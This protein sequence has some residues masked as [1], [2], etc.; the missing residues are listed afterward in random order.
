MVRVTQQSVAY[1]LLLC[2]SAGLVY[3]IAGGGFGEP[4]AE[5]KLAP[6]TLAA[7]VVVPD[8]SGDWLHR[9][10]NYQPPPPGYGN[11]PL[12]N[13]IDSRLIWVGD[14]KNPILKPW[15]AEI[16]KQHGEQEAAG[17]YIPTARAT[18]WPTGVPN[19]MNL[20]QP[21]RILQTPKEVVILYE[22][23]PQVRIIYLNQKHSANPEPSWHGESVGHYEGDTLVVDTIGLN[24]KSWID[25]FGTPST[26]ALHVVERFRVTDGGTRLQ[27]IATVED[28]NTFNQPWSG[29]A[30]YGPSDRPLTEVICAENNRG[31]T[32]G[33]R[34]N[35]PVANYKPPL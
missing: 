17:N 31:A 1:G 10:S 29:M 30:V 24:G 14:Y 18:C 33:T 7:T 26:Q 15:A 20:Q 21:V 27:V 2:A 32:P 4:G 23:G 5:P 25:R 35:I 13:T 19:T 34:A 22:N 9:Q 11:G 16:V 28:P 6:A 12:R 8:L 3:A